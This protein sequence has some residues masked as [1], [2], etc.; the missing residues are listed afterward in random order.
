M[1]HRADVQLAKVLNYFTNL[2]KT[3]YFASTSTSL[4][5]II[6]ENKGHKL[7]YPKGYITQ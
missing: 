4:L 5:K 7:S 6:I 2:L 1:S 3:F